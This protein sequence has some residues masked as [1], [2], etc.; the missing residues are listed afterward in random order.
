MCSRFIEL[1]F[2]LRLYQGNRYRQ[3][4]NF[5]TSGTDG[6]IAILRSQAGA[7][8]YEDVFSVDLCGELALHLIP[9]KDHLRV[10]HRSLFR[11]E[12]CGANRIVLW[13]LAIRAVRAIRAVS[14]C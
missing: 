13:R 12:R 14:G 10:L 5:E 4:S 8:G 2:Q 9:V 11:H 7:E 6:Y 1:L 3:T